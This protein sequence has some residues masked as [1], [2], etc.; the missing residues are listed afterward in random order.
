M[1]AFTPRLPG[2]RQQHEGDSHWL[3]VSDLMASLM[4]IFLFLALLHMVQIERAHEVETEVRTSAA[5]LRQAIY[6]ALEDEFVDDLPRWNAEL[7]RDTLTLRFRE[8]DVLFDRS[9]SR[10]KPEF[11]AILSD[12][13]P[14]YVARLRPFSTVIREIRI[15]GHTSSEW[16]PGSSPLEAYFANMELSQKRTRAVLR[17]A[18]GLEA[19]RHEQWFR[20]RVAAVG[21]SSSRLV[22]DATGHEDPTASRR[23]EFSVLTNFEDRLLAPTGLDVAATP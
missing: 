15:E 10:I 17:F 8:P 9:S 20:Y 2:H 22:L 13:L 16:A 18:Y 23:V 6:H 7:E 12:F 21:L 3:V 1:S 14:R 5:E 19:L 4:M 11:E